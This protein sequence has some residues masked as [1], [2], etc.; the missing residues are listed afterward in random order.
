[1]FMLNPFNFT[2]T[3]KLIVVFTKNTDLKE[4]T[5]IPEFCGAKVVLG[6]CFTDSSGMSFVSVSVT[7]F[8]LF[9]SN[10][11]ISLGVDVNVLTF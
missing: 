1:M 3:I 2:D 10:S 4:A 5:V 11:L 9:S 7:S 6:E 8:F